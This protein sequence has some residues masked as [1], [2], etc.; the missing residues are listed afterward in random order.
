MILG[1]S[2]DGR[3][4]RGRADSKRRDANAQLLINH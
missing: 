3:L 1:G 4:Q 2:D